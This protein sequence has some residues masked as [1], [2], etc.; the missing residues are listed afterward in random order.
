MA[1]KKNANAVPEP[2][3]RTV[4]CD[5]YTGLNVRERP[6]MQAKVVNVIPNGFKV[7]AEPPKRGWCKVEDG[8][9]KGEYLA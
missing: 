1:T 9:V 6:N 3:E 7:M 2:E 5:G 8:Y 4:S